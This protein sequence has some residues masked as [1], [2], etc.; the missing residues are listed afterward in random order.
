MATAKKT[1]SGSWSVLACKNGK[2]KRFTA[3]S[4]RE[5]EKLA[6]DWQYQEEFYEAHLT[7]GQAIDKYI[8]D[9]EDSLSPVSVRT[10]KTIRRN[11]FQSLMDIP[12]SSLNED[13]LQRAINNERIAPKTLRNAF[14]LIRKSLDYSRY[15]ISYTL[16]FPPV[17]K[18]KV[19]IPTREQIIDLINS[20]QGEL[21][22]AI[23]LG[24]YLGLRRSEICALTQSDFNAKEKTLTI[25]KAAVQN[26][27]GEYII[28]CPKTEAGNRTLTVPDN[29]VE[30]LQTIKTE[31]FFSYMPD[32]IT[33][34]F[35]KLVKKKGMEMRFHDLRHYN[36]SV[37][38]ALNV[39][40]PYIIART[41]HTTSNM[42]ETVYG[43]MIPEEQRIV[44]NKLGDFF[45]SEK[46]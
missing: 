4:K 46:L 7:V 24:A 18:H 33:V 23:I 38:L 43:H 30:Y 40:M 36:V 39:P 41:G 5:A 29:V 34:G 14:G 37:M 9:N 25:S 21:K 31:K 27:K 3:A 26:D 11:Y 10:Y 6:S 28:K 35:G 8:E 44:A 2:Y 32:A 45:A 16:K 42:V 12:L 15:K 20:A 22:T 13:I 17:K 1:A 19:T